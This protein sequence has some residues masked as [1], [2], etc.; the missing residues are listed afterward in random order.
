M[1]LSQ[2][3]RNTMPPEGRPAETN[4]QMVAQINENAVFAAMAK[5]LKHQRVVQAQKWNY[6]YVLNDN[7]DGQVTSPFYITIEQGTDFNCQWLTASA[8]SYEDD[9][10]DATTF[11][12]PNSAGA[13]N[14]AGRG[15]SVQV[16]D[17]RS[18]RELTSGFVPF[19]LLGTPGYGMNFQHPF[20]FKYLFYRNSK[21]RFDVRNRDNANRNHEFSIA[22]NGFKILTPE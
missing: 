6:T 11:P 18:G 20:P 16:T 8:F 21:I 12:I 17:M 19:E 9:Q 22:L 3:P 14:W 15:L 4:P 10:G 5:E 13:T 1:N 2:Y 7:I